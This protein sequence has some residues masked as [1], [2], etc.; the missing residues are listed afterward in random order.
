MNKR[1]A[2]FFATASAVSALA[3]AGCGGTSS[4]GSGTSSAPAAATSSAPAAAPSTSAAL[5]LQTST[6]GGQ[7]IVV[8]GKGMTVYY[9]T[10]D[11]PGETTSA[12]TGGCVALWPAV[13]SDTAPTLQ[14][15]TGKIGTLPT[16]DGKQQ[17]T[18]NGMPIYYFSKDTA[19]GQVKGQG[20]AGVWYVVGADGSMIQSPLM[21][22]TSS[23]SSSS[24]PSS[25]TNPSSSSNN[26]GTSGY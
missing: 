3:L 6:V 7:T 11:K 22:T 8:D 15:V 21:A 14:G 19:P 17:V 12:C 25:S 4:S 24:N 20:V 2:L 13:T 5:S 23:P 9:Y 18:I 16:A 26:S 1:A 10:L